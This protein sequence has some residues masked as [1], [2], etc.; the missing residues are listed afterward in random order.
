MTQG[1]RL[2]Q[3]DPV[4]AHDAGR[5]VQLSGQGRVLFRP[6]NVFP[7]DVA[8]FGTTHVQGALAGVFDGPP[9]V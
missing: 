6:V 1:T 3:L 7:V 4:D 9:F 8:V 2:E 5:H